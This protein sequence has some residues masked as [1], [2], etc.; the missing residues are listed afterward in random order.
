MNTSV[1]AGKCP[2]YGVRWPE[3]TTNLIDVGGEECG[4]DFDGHGPC[5]MGQQGE[6]PDIRFCPIAER[7]KNFLAL[8][9]DRVR[10]ISLQRSDALSYEAWKDQVMRRSG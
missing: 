6:L 10:V 3:H 7:A 5:S 9:A 4:L 1:A 8:I 2:F